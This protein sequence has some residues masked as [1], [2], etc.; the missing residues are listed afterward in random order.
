MEKTR[1]DYNLIA[2]DFSRTRE[3]PWEE[4]KFLFDDYFAKGDK[5]LDLGCGNGRYL[6]YFKEK[7]VDYFGIDSSE[8]LIQIAKNKYPEGNFQVADAFNLPFSDNFFDKIFSIAVLHHIPSNELRL[9][10]LKETKRTLKPGGILIVT[11]WRFH[12]IKDLFSIFK[13]NI[14]RLFGLSRFDF[15]DILEPW[16]KTVERYYHCFSRKELKNLL[17]KANFKIKEMEIAKNEKGNRQNIYVVARL[18]KILTKGS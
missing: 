7:E 11:A 14:L 12:K 10:F 4:I 8:K 17:A 9:Q 6:E 2:E 1:Q 3:K 18:D 5:V 15:G 13:S 16:G